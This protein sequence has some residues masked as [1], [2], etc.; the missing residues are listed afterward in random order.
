MLPRLAR[1]M[2]GGRLRTRRLRADATALLK[3]FDV[4]PQNANLSAGELSGGN[5]QKATMA[6]W[7]ATSPRLLLLDEPSQGVDVGAR[8][9]IVATISATARA[10]ACVL[11]ASID[12]EQL[13]ALCG[14]VLVLANGRAVEELTGDQVTTERLA[15]AVLGP[16]RAGVT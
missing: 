5:Q 8:E 10:G 2:Q 9:Q 11:V 6:K 1:Y 16:Q 7:L 15:A 14:S 13:A 12:H 4:R 3:R